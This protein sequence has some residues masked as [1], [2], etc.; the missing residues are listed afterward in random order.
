M[1]ISL[2]FVGYV[3]VS[4]VTSVLYSLYMGTLGLYKGLIGL[5]W[6]ITLPI[7][8]IDFISSMIVRWAEGEC[9]EE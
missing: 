2:C 6:P 3:I 1:T 8:T 7:L 9:E 4:I 5:S